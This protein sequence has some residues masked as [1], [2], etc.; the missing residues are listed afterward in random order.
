M[1]RRVGRS[2]RLGL[3]CPFAIARVC[4][5]PG[6][7]R[8]AYRAICKYACVEKGYQEMFRV[9]VLVTSNG[10]WLT[11]W[12]RSLLRPKLCCWS[13]R[14]RV[15]NLRHTTEKYLVS[16]SC[17]ITC[18]SYGRIV[19]R[20]YQLIKWEWDKQIPPQ[21][22]ALGQ[23]HLLNIPPISQQTFASNPKPNM[24]INKSSYT[25]R[26]RVRVPHEVAEMLRQKRLNRTR[27]PPQTAGGSD[28]Q[29]A[30]SA[31]RKFA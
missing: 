22:N 12:V 21:P 23:A 8:C 26:I 6:L 3:Q 5:V 10:N 2:G 28:S 4:L 13:G 30:D 24:E 20:N 1:M 29:A 27:I 18:E 16:S 14:K 19:A 25:G 17:S 15:P 9:H 11:S 7:A 31:S